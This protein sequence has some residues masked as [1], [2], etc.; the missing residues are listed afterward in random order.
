MYCCI[1]NQEILIALSIQF[2][3]SYLLEPCSSP[4]NVSVSVYVSPLTYQIAWKPIKISEFCGQPR[5]Y[6]V[7]FGVNTTHVMNY[8]SV[9]MN[10]TYSNFTFPNELIRFVY[11][12]VTVAAFTSIGKGPEIGL[13]FYVNDG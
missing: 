10:Y 3:K 11:Y 9:N 13:T 5:G 12:E 4:R 2:V 6:T 8:S 1:N 7:V